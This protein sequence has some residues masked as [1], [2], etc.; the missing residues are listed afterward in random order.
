M[1]QPPKG[2]LVQGYW[3]MFLSSRALWRLFH[4]LFWPSPNLEELLPPLPTSHAPR[5]PPG[6]HNP[7]A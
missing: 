4:Q 1:A 3:E 6:V 5:A 7:Q 2:G